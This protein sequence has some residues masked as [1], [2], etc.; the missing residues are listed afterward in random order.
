MKLQ[1][2]RRDTMMSHNDT[3]YESIYKKPML[4]PKAIVEQ[5]SYRTREAR[6]LSLTQTRPYQRDEPQAWKN[7]I[8]TKSRADVYYEKLTQRIT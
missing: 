7:S 2:Y 1:R 5:A 4:S 6:A 3:S 8:F